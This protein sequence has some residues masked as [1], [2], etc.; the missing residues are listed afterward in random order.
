[1]KR[2]DVQSFD[3]FREYVITKVKSGQFLLY[4]R[5]GGAL[6]NF[7]AKMLGIGCKY[8]K[9]YGFVTNGD[10]YRKTIPESFEGYPNPILKRDIEN[11]S[12]YDEIYGEIIGHDKYGF[13][14]KPQVYNDDLEYC[15]N[16]N[17][18]E[19]IDIFKNTLKIDTDDELIVYM[20]GRGRSDI[21]LCERCHSYL[22]V[23]K[24]PPLLVKPD[25]EWICIRCAREYLQRKNDESLKSENLY[26]LGLIPYITYRI[27]EEKFVNAVLD[28]NREYVVMGKNDEIL[29]NW[30]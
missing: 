24:I 20:N 19:I 25:E 28:E 29:S 21:L 10:E 13:G 26:L 7:F 2:E 3:D 14:G 12:S 9:I 6:Q 30:N 16:L 15:V 17:I 4:S 5:L 18:D 1:M 23:T 8:D 22:F 11:N 27:G